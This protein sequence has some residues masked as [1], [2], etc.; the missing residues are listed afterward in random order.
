METADI[1][2]LAR[3]L[4]NDPVLMAGL[5]FATTFLLEDAAALAAAFLIAEGLMPP[6]LG[7]GAVAGGIFI[8]DLW[9][10][11]MGRAALQV[12]WLRRKIGQDRLEAARIWLDKR[13]IVAVAVARV[14]PT[15]RL[16][17]YV[18]LG[19]TKVSLRRFA[20]IAFVCVGLWTFVLFAAADLLAALTQGLGPWRWAV[21]AAV[22]LAAAMAPFILRRAARAIPGGRGR[23]RP[24]AP[25]LVLGATLAP[26]SQEAWGGPG[27]D[28]DHHAR[29]RA[30]KVEHLEARGQ[31]IALRRAGDPD[32]RPVL[33]LHGTPGSSEGWARSLLDPPAGFH[34]VA[35]D[36]PGFGLTRPAHPLPSLEEQADALGPVLARLGRDGYGRGRPIVMGH[37]LGG[38]LAT[39]LA[40]RHGADL[41]GLVVAGGALDPALER[42]HPAQRLALRAPL[43]QLLP[44]AL[45]ACNRELVALKDGL[46][47]LSERLDALTVPTEI[48]HGAADD[49]VPAENVAFMRARF[50]NVSRLGVTVL[51]GRDHFLPWKDAAELHHALSRLAAIEGKSEPC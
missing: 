40:I 20:A 44:R 42:V 32:G 22:I 29:A 48:V 8:G 34:M 28:R 26:G 17:T 31:A 23:W 3:A 35:V 5:L 13:L 38:P 7:Y 33:L 36:R 51:P 10:Y 14:L 1:L 2:E 6:A 39:L 49:L 16:P 25:L 19:Y 30:L 43:R 4:G 9:L 45:D 24:P 41:A 37:S 47:R 21:F 15:V 27:P 18:G 12:G 50:T 46:D 11:G